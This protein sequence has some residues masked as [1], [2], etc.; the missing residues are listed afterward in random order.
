MAADHKRVVLA[1]DDPE[2]AQ[3]IITVLQSSGYEVSWVDKKDEVVDIAK[4]T[5]AY[6]IILDLVLSD[7]V[8][9][10]VP[11]EIKNVLGD[12]CYVIVVTGHSRSYPEFSMQQKGAD[13]VLR[14]P[15]PAMAL[16]S[17]LQRTAE[18]DGIFVHQRSLVYKGAVI[19]LSTGDVYYHD[20]RISLPYN[21]QN[22]LKML[23]VRSPE[24]RWALVDTEDIISNIWGWQ[25]ETSSAVSADHGRLRGAMKRL[26]DRVSVLFPE[27]G[28]CEWIKNVRGTNRHSFY[29]LSDDVELVDSGYTG[30]E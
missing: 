26:R 2:V 27:D 5:G 8:A 6:W 28:E 24:G 13:F 14:K 1:E 16:R 10:D 4:E 19:R 25:V 30:H 7:G 20:Q 18:R 3:G 11:E 15:Y 21:D 23:V 12:E 9:V 29:C 17:L 22:L